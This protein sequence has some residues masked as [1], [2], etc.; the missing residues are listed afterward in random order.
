MGSLQAALNAAGA[1]ALAPAAFG[2]ATFNAR[3]P[4]QYD[5]L[6]AGADAIIIG[7]IEDNVDAWW[8]SYHARQ[9]ESRAVPVLVLTTEWFYSAVRAGAQD[10]GFAAMR[11]V[12]IPN[13][14]WA[15][16]QGFEAVT[17]RR[18]YVDNSIV[19]GT[20]NIGAA[21]ITA[22]TGAL[23]PAEQSA[24]PLTLAAM[25]LP[26][27]DGRRLLSIPGN[28]AI[29]AMPAFHALSMELG[30]GDGLPLVLPTEA[31][32]SAMVAG[33]GTNARA[34]D[35]VLGRVMLRGGIMTVENVAANAVMA[36]ARPE[37]FPIILAAMEAYIN[38]WEDN[39]L[40]YRS[41]MSNDLRSLVMVVSGPIVGDGPGQIDLARG[42]TLDLGKNCS[43]VI[44]RAVMLSIRNIG[45]IA[46]ENS[47]V[48]GLSRFNP[49]ELWVVAE[50]NEFLPAGW[51]TLSEQ[52]GFGGGSNTVTLLS[53]NHARFVGGVGGTAAGGT[54]GAFDGFA[55]HRV[56]ASAGNLNN[57][58]G[59]FLVHW[60]DAHQISSTDTRSVIQGGLAQTAR[61]ISSK[62]MLQQ[63]IAGTGGDPVIDGPSPVAIARN[64]NRE[65]LVWPIVAAFGHS[66]QGRVYHGGSPDYND[67][68]GFH[69]QRIGSTEAQMAP[70]AP[71]AFAVDVA[72]AGQAVLSWAAPAR[73]TSVT[74][75]VSH[76]GGRTWIPA[77]GTTHTFT[78]LE[79]GQYF[80]AVRARN[81]VQ[82]SAD[83][84]E[85]GILGAAAQVDWASSGRGAWA[86]H[87]AAVVAP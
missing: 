68:R 58:P 32:V 17:A 50:A 24:A 28:D 6:A 30:F 41:I 33:Q 67:S 60:R 8:V 21:V 56:Q 34:A 37:H 79:A 64:E 63:W 12:T 75:E 16:A 83:I 66:V 62:N 20:V 59:I 72:T 55:A 36:G 2:G 44:G 71:T 47:S 42:R 31:A 29:R 27:A 53:V 48:M 85:P 65:A 46:F 10:N 45:H 1:T 80:F 86:W 49:H 13:A 14:P 84:R 51:E 70:S 7:V 74:Y 69:T 19:G 15:D 87:V 9:I 76:D 18:T 40:F 54:A 39:K 81:N 25:G 26:Y 78:N 22:L 35:E 77:S 82:N 23:T 5:D 4:A 11:I 43:A 61:G 3:T 38:G 73:G 52:M 57:A